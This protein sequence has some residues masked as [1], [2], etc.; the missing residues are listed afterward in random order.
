MNAYCTLHSITPN[1][2]VEHLP[3][4]P[5]TQHS[6]A[7]NIKQRRKCTRSNNF[8]LNAISERRVQAQ[9]YTFIRCDTIMAIYSTHHSIH[10]R[11]V[12]LF[13][14]QLLDSTVDANRIVPTI[15]LDAQA[16]APLMSCGTAH[17]SIIHIFTWYAATM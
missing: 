10:R 12:I 15:V 2:I 13:I 16:R 14:A 11:A 8:L 3:C 6:F 5:S 9:L 17:K 1:T 7:F 4:L